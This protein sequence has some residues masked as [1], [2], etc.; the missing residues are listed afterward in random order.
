MKKENKLIWKH[1]K[2]RGKKENKIRLEDR[3]KRRK[4]REAK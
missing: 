3:N 1:R 2:D 4:E